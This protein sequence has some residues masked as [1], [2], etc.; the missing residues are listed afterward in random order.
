MP[1]PDND[2]YE[3]GDFRLDPV[4]RTLYHKDELVPLTPK[5]IDTLMALVR[6]AGHV[7]SKEEL[8]Q[9]VWPDTFVEEGNLNV[10]IFALR[11]ALGELTPE[12]NFI[13][14]VPRRGYRFVA[15]VRPADRD[16]ETLII[17]RRTRARIITEIEDDSS[18]AL[19]APPVVPV[20]ALPAPRSSRIPRWL[21]LAVAL[22]FGAALILVGRW[23]LNSRPGSPVRISLSGKKL[24]AWD[25]KG[26]LD[27]EFEFAQPVALEEGVDSHPVIF[28]DLDGD[29]HTEVLV[30]VALPPLNLPVTPHSAL[31]CFSE[32]GKLLW[33]Y[34]PQVKFHFGDRE[35]SSP[36]NLSA[37][38]IVPDGNEKYVWAV[39]RHPLW[40]PS[41]VVRLDRRGAAEVRFVNSGHILFLKPVHGT[42]GDYLLAAGINNEF[43]SGMLA[44]LRTDQPLSPSPQS[45]D[46]PYTCKECGNP[47]PYMYYY[48]PRSEIFDLQN[49]SFHQVSALELTPD[50]IRVT[51]FEGKDPA[52]APVHTSLYAFYEF[53]RNFE[54]KSA[55]LSDAYWDMHRALEKEGKI[56][57]SAEQ[58]P[59][60]SIGKRLRVWVPHFGLTSP[61]IAASVPANNAV[62]AKR[63]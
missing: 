2:F 16:G 45:S 1:L 24:Y 27:W 34:D 31:Y 49:D 62:L 13:E 21:Y 14:T 29:G 10:N 12:Q 39:F 6:H 59:D 17:E 43:R 28:S 11:K 48:F 55:S 22:V 46:S 38:Q 3:F 23:Y 47:T 51:T 57:H 26:R 4:E 35:F 18:A 41:F 7:V 15:P 40:W 19:P 52:A 50:A 56:H 53:G 20:A 9:S 42:T 5:A 30:K 25:E 63:D 54:L 37:L 60:R 8:I 36:W 33:S 44:V 58:C 32:R 61:R